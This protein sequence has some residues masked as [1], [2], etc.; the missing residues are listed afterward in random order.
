[1]KAFDSYSPV[2]QQTAQALK[3]DGYETACRYLG[4]KT[5]RLPNGLTPIEVCALHK[6]GLSIV[7]IFELNPTHIGYFTYAQ[8]LRDA[9]NAVKEA[10]W[11]RQPL[12]TA[13]YFTVDFDAQEQDFLAIFR[14]FEGVRKNLG[15]YRLG[16]YGG[17]HTVQK[18][19]D[20]AI[21]PDF[22]WQTI[23]WSNGQLFDRADVYQNEVNLMV[24]GLG[25]DADETRVAN[26]GAWSEQK[27][28]KSIIRR[29]M[30]R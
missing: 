30:K 26:F 11:L 19:F 7:S 27:V 24:A 23:A 3:K 5:L 4:A 22:L 16:V 20:S 8:G 2:T 6:E 9:R 29:L 1:M 17:I 15:S 14:Y 28:K 13:I 21:R 12:H 18:L 25:I 10:V